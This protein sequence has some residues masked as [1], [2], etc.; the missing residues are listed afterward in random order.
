MSYSHALQPLGQR[1]AFSIALT[2]VLREFRPREGASP[3]I[4]L[5]ADVLN[6]GDDVI[7]AA[8]KRWLTASRSPRAASTS[9]ISFPPP[10]VVMKE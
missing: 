6:Y 8:G 3:E 1:H 10:K 7:L 5:Y 9:S 4:G 2:A